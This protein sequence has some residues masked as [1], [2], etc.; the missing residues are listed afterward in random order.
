MVADT[1]LAING[2]TLDILMANYTANN[3]EYFVVNETVAPT[4]SFGQVE[5]NGNLETL[6][7]IGNGEYTFTDS[8]TGDQFELAYNGVYSTGALTGGQ[9][10]VVLAVPEPTSLSVIGFGAMG[11][12]ASR[13][14]RRASRKQD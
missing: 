10:I 7:S 9:D 5:V 6:T 12:L 14:R 13:R 2:A 3:S 4:G 1:G 8:S 11:L